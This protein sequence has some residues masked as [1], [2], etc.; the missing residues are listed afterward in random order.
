MPL[1]L[2]IPSNLPG[3]LEAGMSMHFGH[4]DIYTLV[5][6]HD[7]NSVA[8]VTTLPNIPHEQGG[9]MAS[10]QHLAAHGVNRVLAGGMGM[11]PLQGFQQAGIEV[12]AT[13]PVATVG[14]AVEAFRTGSLSAFTTDLTCRGGHHHH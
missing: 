12:F 5:D 14:E 11:R 13:G 4:C 9:C 8:T 10:V 6:L 3:G 1:R 7:D 2:A